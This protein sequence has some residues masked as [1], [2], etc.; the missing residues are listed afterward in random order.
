[1]GLH[2]YISSM[3]GMGNIQHPIRNA[4]PALEVAGALRA[5]TARSPGKGIKI[6]MKSKIK[7]LGSLELCPDGRSWVGLRAS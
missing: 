1:M 5:E 6:K 4:L 3:G 2:R 7:K